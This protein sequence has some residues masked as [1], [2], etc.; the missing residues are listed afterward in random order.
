MLKP[1]HRHNPYKEAD[2][3]LAY[4]QRNPS[5]RGAAICMAHGGGVISSIMLGDMKG[6]KTAFCRSI[7]EHENEVLDS[8]TER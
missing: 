4:L 3:L 6:A 1:G 2:K 8:N 5:F 7:K